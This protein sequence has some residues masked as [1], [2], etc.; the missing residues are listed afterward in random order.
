MNVILFMHVVFLYHK[1][2]LLHIFLNRVMGRDIEEKYS[3]I[4]IKPVK[5]T[6]FVV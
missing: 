4:I 5:N 1:H 2:T 3:S 6:S